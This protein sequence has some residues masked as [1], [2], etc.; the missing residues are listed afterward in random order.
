M[1]V[2]M[3]A[4]IYIYIYVCVILLLLI[5]MLR[6]W[7]RGFGVLELRISTHGL[8]YSCRLRYLA[9]E[10]A[11][12]QAR[13]R[14]DYERRA[15]DPTMNRPALCMCECVIYQG[16]YLFFSSSGVFHS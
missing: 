3:H 12:G 16:S 7:L 15:V 13:C 14:H 8:L 10:V 5:H 4:Y 9:A 6:A 11:V 2:C 1:Y